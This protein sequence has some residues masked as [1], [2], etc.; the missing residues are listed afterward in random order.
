MATSKTRPDQFCT[1]WHP[2]IKA[3][4]HK[5]KERGGFKTNAQ[6]FAAIVY[7]CANSDILDPQQQNRMEEKLDWLLEFHQDL[8]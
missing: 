3:L 5:I 1:D 2:E 4:F 8:E 6:T 7:T